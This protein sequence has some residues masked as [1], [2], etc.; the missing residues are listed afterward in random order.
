[1]MHV[2]WDAARTHRVS[3]CFGSHRRGRDPGCTR[4]S[5]RAPASIRKERRDREI[6][7]YICTELRVHVT[8]RGGVAR[9]KAGSWCPRTGV[10]G[11]RLQRPRLSA[12]IAPEG[13]Q[14]QQKFESAGK[15]R[16]K[17]D[18][19]GELCGEWL[20]ARDLL[21]SARA[22]QSRRHA[23]LWEGVSQHV[24]FRRRVARRGEGLRVGPAGRGLGEMR[25]GL[26]RA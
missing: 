20:G 22:L 8:R 16:T 4:A 19:R 15:P 9:E 1:M 24:A 6:Y 25:C 3:G 10:P 7:G 11:S 23:G 17:I 18:S 5:P 2:R 26:A 13:I 14:S 12:R 21:S